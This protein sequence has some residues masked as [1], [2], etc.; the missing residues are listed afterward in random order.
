M[1]YL[2]HTMLCAV[3]V[4]PGTGLNAQSSQ[5]GTLSIIESEGE[6]VHLEEPATT[7]FV[8]DPEIAS[9]QVVSNS[10]VF[11][12]GHAEGL[13]TLYA[14]DENDEVMMEREIAVHRSLTHMMESL[15]GVDN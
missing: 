8:A 4:L 5:I 14:L 10:T 12:L 6:F 3:L 2:A 9:L 13:T 15:R 11:V 7:I 1:K